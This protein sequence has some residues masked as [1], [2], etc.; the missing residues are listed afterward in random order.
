VIL[1]PAGALGAAV[2]GVPLVN[3]LGSGNPA[4]LEVPASLWQVV[5]LYRRLDFADYYDTLCR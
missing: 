2:E 5:R 1:T 4:A 3:V